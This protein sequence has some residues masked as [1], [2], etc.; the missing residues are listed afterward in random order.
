MLEG[1]PC[2]RRILDTGNYWVDTRALLL[3]CIEQNLQPTTPTVWSYT[4]NSQDG[5]RLDLSA[6]GVWGGRFE[7][8]LFGIRIFNLHARAHTARSTWAKRASEL[9]QSFFFH[10]LL[11]LKLWMARCYQY[12][13]AYFPSPYTRITSCFATSAT[14]SAGSRL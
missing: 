8:T 12:E 14:R 13:S 7:K 5:A 11:P 10:A 2:A 4:A 9:K 6:N 1:R 3:L